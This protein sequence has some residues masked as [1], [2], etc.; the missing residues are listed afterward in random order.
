MNLHEK[1]C[2]RCVGYELQSVARST[3]LGFCSDSTSFRHLQMISISYS[4]S[5]RVTDRGSIRTQVQ[6]WRRMP[7]PGLPG[8]IGA[9]LGGSK[10]WRSSGGRSEPINYPGANLIAYR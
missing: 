3:V 6:P 7:I 9:R 5:H 10:P 4:N 8:L 1:C 2:L